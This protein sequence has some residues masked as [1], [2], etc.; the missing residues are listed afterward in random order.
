M[1]GKGKRETTTTRVDGVV[2]T[3]PREE[4]EVDVLVKG[5]NLKE[6]NFM[7]LLQTNGT[8]LGLTI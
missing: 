4:K 2:T 5:P 1:S 7:N 3:D 8:N 6:T